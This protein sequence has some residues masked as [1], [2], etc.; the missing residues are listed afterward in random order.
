MGAI[1]LIVCSML[2]AL[3]VALLGLRVADALADRAAIARLITTQPA[4]PPRFDPAMVDDLPEPARRYF[5]YTIASGTPLWTVAEISMSGD[6]GLGTRTAPGYR[7][8]RARQILSAPRGFVWQVRSGIASGSDAATDETSWS[9]FRLFGII[10]VGRA[11]GDSDHARS[12]F[13]RCVAEAAF[14]TPA[15]LLPRDGIV[16]SELSDD[17]AQCQVARGDLTQAVE[18]KVGADGQPLAISFQRWANANPE[19]TYRLQPF[20]GDLSEFREFG[21]FRLPTRVEGGNFFGTDQYFPFYR[22]E[23]QEIRFPATR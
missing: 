7:P 2:T 10:P 19:K 5:S 3:F 15:V 6:L 23:V 22:A 9:R 20:G 12:S 21:G 13:G 17:T 14:W 8:M 1:L 18:I 16:W 4:S 11:G